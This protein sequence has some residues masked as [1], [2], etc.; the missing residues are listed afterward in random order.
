L[1][2]QHTMILD[3]GDIDIKVIV[4]SN[5][6]V[7]FLDKINTPEGS[8][9]NNNIENVDAV[10]EAINNLK[11]EKNIRVSNVVFVI[12]GQDVII[13]HTTV[14]IMEYNHIADSAKWEMS[15]YLPENG[16][17][18]YINF[19]ILDKIKNKDESI[20]NLV[21]AAAPREKIDK[22]AEVSK[23]LGIK[24]LA[25]DIA[26]NCVA[27]VFSSIYDNDNTK[28]NIGIIKLGNTE[29]NI[30]ILDKGRLFIERELPFGIDNII[31]QI[32]AKKGLSK[33]EAISYLKENIDLTKIDK[34][35]ENEARIKRLFDNVFSSF[36][37]VIQFFGTGRAKKKLDK[38]Y[39]IGSGAEIKNIDTYIKGF[40]DIDTTIVNST[41]DVFC[42]FPDEHEF[43][44]YIAPFGAL[45]RKGQNVELNLIPY[46]L[47]HK[48]GTI[49]TGKKE[50]MIAGIIIACMIVVAVIP[51][52]YI[53]KLNSDNSDLKSQL[54]K[55]VW[56]GS[57]NKKLNDKLS[58]YNKQ[59]NTVAT[60]QKGKVYVLKW[61]EGIV[62]QLPSDATTDSIIKDNKQDNI[63]IAGET[64][65]LNSVTTFAN[66][67]E[68]SGLYKDVKII[69]INQNTEGG[70][71]FIITVEEVIK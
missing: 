67:L 68:N 52:L 19:Q 48:R 28:E 57:Q 35:D 33:T 18:H 23:K 39:V 22:F 70:Y 21:V 46:D 43:K 37:K 13:R 12:K 69:S 62:K 51:R 40:L 54:S 5:K 60:V 44:K 47:D 50:R 49:L 1:F 36:E 17:E 11:T 53:M 55:E 25:I 45:I 3:I 6:K 27:R 4:G 66:N 24:L 58:Q 26:A 42:K 9:I 31:K 2:N 71:K 16:E 29:S 20:Y 63:N 14:P 32:I 10:V 56:I 30:I 8:V 59:M 61:I 34:N 41:S 7:S 15:Q 64:E 65:N 38:I